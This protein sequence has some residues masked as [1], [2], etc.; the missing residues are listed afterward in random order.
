MK[1]VFILPIFL[2]LSCPSL[3]AG[4]TRFPVADIPTELKKDAKAVI[5]YSN[6]SFEVHSDNKATYT[7]AYA[8]T[9]LK[10]DALQM[11]DLQLF[12]DNTSRI[13]NI[14]AVVYNEAGEKVNRVLSADILDIA[15]YM[16]F[17]LYHDNRLKLV[18]T[19]YQTV[20]FTVE[21]EYTINYNSLMYYPIWMPHQNFD[22]SVEQ[23][24]F[25]I[26]STIDHPIR[27]KEQ[28]LKNKFSISTIDNKKVYR[29]EV[30][31]LTPIK[32]EPICLPFSEYAPLVYLAPNSFKYSKHNGS[33]ESWNQFGNSYNFV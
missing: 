27:Y 29:W 3:F 33:M 10:T 18:D 6:E 20:P 5:R 19:E 32:K 31:G 26:A 1:P 8:I 21:F 28:N 14:S 4:K 7:I 13:S 23:A 16:D 2:S 11:A 15:A 22:I 12:Y 24:S 30:E 9:I 17:S 25:T